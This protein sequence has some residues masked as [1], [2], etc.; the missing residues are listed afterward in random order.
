MPWPPPGDLPEPR[1][2][3]R[4]PSLKADSLPPELPGKPK[5]RKD[6]VERFVS[7]TLVVD[8]HKGLEEQGFEHTLIYP[9]T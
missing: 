7:A 9:E 6:R 1:I 4:S 2:E 8:M 5:E 3:P